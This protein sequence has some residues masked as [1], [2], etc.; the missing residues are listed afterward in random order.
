LSSLAPLRVGPIVDSC[1]GN[2]SRHYGSEK[3]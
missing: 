1:T 3:R 2:R